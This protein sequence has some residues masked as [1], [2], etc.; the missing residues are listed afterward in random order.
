MEWVKA[1][2]PRGGWG[3]SSPAK[4]ARLSPQMPWGKME[5]LLGKVAPSHPFAKEL[6]PLLCRGRKLVSAPELRSAS[7]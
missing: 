2:A 4:S 6:A 3:D 7:P 1:A 5:A